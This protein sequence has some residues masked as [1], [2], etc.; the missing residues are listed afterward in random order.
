MSCLGQGGGSAPPVV[1]GAAPALAK[2]GAGGYVYIYIYY[3][4]AMYFAMYASALRL[5]S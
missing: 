3:V 5:D 4:V 2:A 1:P